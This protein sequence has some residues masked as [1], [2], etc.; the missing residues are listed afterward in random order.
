MDLWTATFVA[1]GLLSQV[2]LLLY[3]AARRWR[4]EAE[5]RWG[6]GIYA[7]GLP[8]AGLALVGVGTAA[9]PEHALAF[10]LFAAWATFGALVDLRLRIEWRRPIR[11]PI[12]GV[13]VGWFVATQFAFWV[14]LWWNRGVAWIAFAAVYAVQTTV[15]VLGHRAG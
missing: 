2:G 9:P 3:F 11:P 12:F 1:F 4:P 15:N 7:L 8:A 6:W 14:P 13:Y 10:A 5:R